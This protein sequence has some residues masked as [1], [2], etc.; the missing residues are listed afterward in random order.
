MQHITYRFFP[1][2]NPNSGKFSRAYRVTRN[3]DAF[4]SFRLPTPL[5]MPTPFPAPLSHDASLSP[6]FFQHPQGCYLPFSLFSARFPNS[7]AYLRDTYL[8]R[9]SG[10]LT[11]VPSP[12]R[13]H[14]HSD[15]HPP[16]HMLVQIYLLRLPT[17]AHT[18]TDTQIYTHSL[19]YIVHSLSTDDEKQYR[20]KSF[21]WILISLSFDLVTSHV[22]TFIYYTVIS[23]ITIAFYFKRI[24]VAKFIYI[25][26][27]KF[28]FFYQKNEELCKLLYF[29]ITA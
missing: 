10:N 29:I 21:D 3:F 6:Y 28:L 13:S 5:H 24:L 22:D 9:L 8:P 12:E 14:C 26:I 17:F 1:E 20:K 11:P 23:Y 16:T 4:F 2:Y 25:K 27:Q 15:I 18:F 7:V 19:S